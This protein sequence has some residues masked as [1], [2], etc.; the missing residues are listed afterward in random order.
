MLLVSVLMLGALATVTAAEPKEPMG[1]LVL[2]LHTDDEG[3]ADAAFRIANV[4]LS[5]GHKVSVL[6]RIKAIQLVL[7]DEDYELGGVDSKKK[8]A[9]FMKAGANVFVGGGC[10]KLQ[11][12]AKDKLVPGVQVGNPDSVMGMIFEQGSKIICM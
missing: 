5:R 3:T 4:A 2:I 10:L 12:I 7:K 11:G 6:L 9:N 8:I 1:S